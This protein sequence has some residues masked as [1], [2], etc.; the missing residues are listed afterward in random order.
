MF[1]LFNFFTKVTSF[2]FKKRQEV[3][4]AVFNKT[5][6][7]LTKLNQQQLDYLTKV[8]NERSKLDAEATMTKNAMAENLRVIKKLDDFLN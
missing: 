1:K 6:D 7:A 5:K 8:E 4:L 3:I 2:T